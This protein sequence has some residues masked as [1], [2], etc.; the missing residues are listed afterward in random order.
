MP[1]I[2]CSLSNSEFSNDSLS[3][4][5]K[6]MLMQQKQQMQQQLKDKEISSYQ[7]NNRQV[8]ENQERQG[9]Q[10]QGQT[11]QLM[12]P[13]LP[14]FNMAASCSGRNNQ[15]QDQIARDQFQLPVNPLGPHPYYVPMSP[16]LMDPY[17]NQNM[18]FNMSGQ[19]QGQGQTSLAPMGIGSLGWRFPY[20]FV[21]QAQQTYAPQYP[22][23]FPN[24]YS[25]QYPGQYPGQYSGQYSGQGPRPFDSIN[26]F[27]SLEN[28]NSEIFKQIMPINRIDELLHIILIILIFLFVIQLVELILN[29]N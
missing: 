15:F 10:E 6:K 21:P 18:Y 14:T 27:S 2:A 22:Q 19:G 28:F 5:E 7:K 23:V 26:P 16:F 3:D 4:W 1:S 8:Q 17:Y 20:N 13:N 25:T 9:Q 12:L 24:T 29:P 11:N